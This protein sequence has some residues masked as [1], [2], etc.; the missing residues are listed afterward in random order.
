MRR[1][2]VTGLGAVTP[3]GVGVAR[4]WHRLLANE[5]GIVSVASRQPQARWAELTSS[6]A[7]VV[8]VGEALGQWN[9]A[10][11]LSASERRRMSTFAQYA[12]AAGDMALKDAGWE[13]TRPEHREVTGVCL[14]SGIGNLEDIYETSLSHHD[15]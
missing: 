3:L 7:G 11:W 4:T 13:V 1:V 15:G 8:P 12:M 5:S 6:V 10:D 2:V 9:P 14:G